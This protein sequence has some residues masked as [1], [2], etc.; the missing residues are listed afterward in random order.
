MLIYVSRCSVL[1][2]ISCVVFTTY[3]V[4]LTQ[5]G[6][7]ILYFLMLVAVQTVFVYV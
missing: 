4:Y 3:A 2:N 5:G 7:E 1:Y 6:V